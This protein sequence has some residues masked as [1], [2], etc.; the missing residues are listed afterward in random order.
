MQTD[1]TKNYIE[2]LQ[3]KYINSKRVEISK[4]SSETTFVPK[5]MIFDKTDPK[6]VYIIGE[7]AEILKL[8]KN[9]LKVDWILNID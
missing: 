5:E 9:T 8:D 7:K 4:L 1:L 6:K 2:L 3:V